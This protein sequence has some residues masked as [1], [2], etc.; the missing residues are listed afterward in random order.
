VRRPVDSWTVEIDQINT[1]T[2]A[3]GAG[4]AVPLIFTST[5][6]DAGPFTIFA[7]GPAATAS[8]TFTWGQSLTAGTPYYFGFSEDK[9][10][11]EFGGAGGGGSSLIAM[12]NAW[13]QRTNTNPPAGGTSGSTGNGDHFGGTGY[14][15]V[16]G[17][18]GT[19]HYNLSFEVNA[20]PEPSAALL[21]LFGFGL[22]VRR[23]R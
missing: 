19:R 1:G 22:F 20:I 21:S 12:T 7:A 10:I 15:D 6:G 8:G 17:L 2:P 14:N 3:T 18:L 23:R 4:A 16:S 13:T 5:G 9:N 11:V